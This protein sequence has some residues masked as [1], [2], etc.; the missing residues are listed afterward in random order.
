MP[1]HSVVVAKV[2]VFNRRVKMSL[3]S[4]DMNT[5]AYLKQEYNSLK[6]V[7]GHAKERWDLNDN[8]MSIVNKWFEFRIKELEDLD[9]K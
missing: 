5:L 4:I 9:K 6:L 2:L 1:Q 3:S 8:E 7:N